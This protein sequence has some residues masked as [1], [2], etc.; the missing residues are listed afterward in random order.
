MDHLAGTVTPSILDSADPADPADPVD[1]E[2]AV[3]ADGQTS[4]G[5]REEVLRWCAGGATAR[6][7]GRTLQGLG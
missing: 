6:Y 2:R 5:R 4:G 3:R 1:V 7:P